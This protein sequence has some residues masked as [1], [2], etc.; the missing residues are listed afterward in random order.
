MPKRSIA[1]HFRSRPYSE[2]NVTVCKRKLSIFASL[3]ELP[4]S[5]IARAV[6]PLH[7]TY[8]VTHSVEPG[9]FI[10]CS[11][12][13]LM[14]TIHKIELR[15]SKFADADSGAAECLYE[16]LSA[17]I[18]R[19]RAILSCLLQLLMQFFKSSFAKRSPCDTLQSNKHSLGKI[20][21][22]SLL[23][24]PLAFLIDLALGKDELRLLNLMRFV[25][26]IS[27]R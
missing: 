1:T 21:F 16:F 20:F 12:L 27:L 5:F 17:E 26:F 8:S 4:D 25:V 22:E 24:L 2:I 3:T 18:L 14:N 10:Y 11:R 13:V 15:P 19:K 9:T 6:W 7:C 23:E